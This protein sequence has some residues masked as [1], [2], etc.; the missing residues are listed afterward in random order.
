MYKLAYIAA[1]LTYDCCDIQVAD[2]DAMCTPTLFWNST[3]CAGSTDSPI[4]SI[5]PQ[6]NT[7]NSL[8]SPV[9][10]ST[11][12]PSTDSSIA[13]QPTSTTPPVSP[14]SVFSSSPWVPEKARAQD[15]ATVVHVMDCSLC[16][17]SLFPMTHGYI[18]IEVMGASPSLV[19]VAHAVHSGV[20]LS[21]IVVLSLSA[22]MRHSS[23]QVF[24]FTCFSLFFLSKFVD[25]QGKLID[26]QEI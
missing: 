8:A 7:T 13:P 21:D 24:A 10:E 22:G 19:A 1:V 25:F 14:S 17:P 16:I 5:L 2:V 26:L 20:A 4:I 12:T 11:V 18:D 6:T 23:L 15:H 9:R 3:T